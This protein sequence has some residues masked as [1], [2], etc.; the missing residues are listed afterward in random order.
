MSYAYQSNKKE[1]NNNF[2][3]KFMA[4]NLLENRPIR[5]V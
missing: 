5:F 3:T 4:L 1:K 2:D